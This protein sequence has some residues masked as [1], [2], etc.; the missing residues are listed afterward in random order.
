MIMMM[1]ITDTE[2]PPAAATAPGFSLHSLDRL[3]DWLQV[4]LFAE[5]ELLPAVAKALTRRRLQDLIDRL[6][7]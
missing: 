2:H 5:A 3:L 4:G 7:C 6:I 1:A